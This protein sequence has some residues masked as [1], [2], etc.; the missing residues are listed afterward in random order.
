MTNQKAKVHFVGGP[1]DG[2]D[3]EYFSPLPK[4]LAL[5]SKGAGWEDYYR[6]PN[7]TEYVYAADIIPP[8]GKCR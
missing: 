8:R 1:H 6:K 5:H 4:I 7:S 3:S 2:E